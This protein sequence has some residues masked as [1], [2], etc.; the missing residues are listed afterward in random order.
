MRKKIFLI[1]KIIIATVLLYLVFEIIRGRIIYENTRLEETNIN[2]EDYEGII[3]RFTPDTIKVNYTYLVDESDT[4]ITFD[5]G[6]KTGLLW[7]VSGSKVLN[8]KSSQVHKRND[9]LELEDGAYK[10]FFSG[11][12]PLLSINYKNKKNIREESQCNFSVLPESNVN[13][14]NSFRGIDNVWQFLVDGV[15]ELRDTKD[16]LIYRI[17][18]GRRTE[19]FIFKVNSSVYFLS[20]Q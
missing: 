13:F 14:N 15:F 7:V 8:L 16:N 19:L 4:I 17:E 3:R 10:T 20:I 1:L 6:N 18:L 11:T 2:T 12:K 5:I 9:I